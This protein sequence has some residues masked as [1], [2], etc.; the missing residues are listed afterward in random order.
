M[1]F[2]QHEVDFPS[3][4]QKTDEFLYRIAQCIDFIAFA[5]SV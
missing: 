1:L 5:F 4:L 3:F 2:W